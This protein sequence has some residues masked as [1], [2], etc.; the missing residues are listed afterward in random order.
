MNRS[1]DWMVSNEVM[2]AEMAAINAEIAELK[3][4]GKVLFHQRIDFF[5]FFTFIS[6]VLN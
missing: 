4:A 6:D 5:F 2:E 1:V 3:R